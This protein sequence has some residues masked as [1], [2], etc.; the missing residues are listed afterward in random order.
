LATDEDLRETMA[1]DGLTRA[2]QFSWTRSAEVTDALIGRL[3]DS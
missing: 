2:A 3:L 1:V